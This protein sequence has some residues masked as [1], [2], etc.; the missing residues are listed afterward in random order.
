M[1]SHF[2]YFKTSVK[3]YNCAALSQQCNLFSWETGCFGYHFIDCSG[4]L[5]LFFC[6]CCLFINILP[7]H[8]LFQIILILC[9]TLTKKLYTSKFILRFFCISPT[10]LQTWFILGKNSLKQLCCVLYTVE[11]GRLNAQSCVIQNLLNSLGTLRSSMYLHFY[12][13]KLLYCRY[14]LLVA[15][16]GAFSVDFGAGGQ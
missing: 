2:L 6:C 8:E 9:S 14:R 5:S 3:N 4:S 13:H 1:C 11:C 12:V 15:D 16:A 7:A 10:T